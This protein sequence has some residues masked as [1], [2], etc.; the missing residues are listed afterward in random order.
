MSLQSYC[1]AH[2]L[3]KLLSQ[4]HLTKNGDMTPADVAHSSR[5]VVWWCCDKGHEWQTQVG[6]RIS[7]TGCPHCYAERLA[8]KR[9]QRVMEAA[10]KKGRKR[11]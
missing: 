8:A 2:G 3:E 11:D 7:G 4:W 9:E 1:E 6:S 10:K 5:T